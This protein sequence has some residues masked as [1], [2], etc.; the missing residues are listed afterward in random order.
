M[1]SPFDHYTKRGIKNTTI[2]QESARLT[3]DGDSRLPLKDMTTEN[4]APPGEFLE[5]NGQSQSVK[6]W[7]LELPEPHATIFRLLYAE[8]MKQRPA[9]K[10]MGISQPRV[11]QLHRSFLDLAQIVFAD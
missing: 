7:V 11:A 10:E 9:A 8:G 6:L 1:T 5:E 3:R 4:G 2:M